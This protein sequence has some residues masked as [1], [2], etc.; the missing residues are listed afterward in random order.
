MGEE[1]GASGRVVELTSVVA[2]NALNRAAKLGGRHEKKLANIG[3][4]SYFRGSGNRENE[5]SHQ[6]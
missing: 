5:S 2:L 3:Y 1:E 6:E 4:I